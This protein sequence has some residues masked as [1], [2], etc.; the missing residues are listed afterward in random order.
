MRDHAEPQRYYDWMVWKMRQEDEKEM[1]DSE[2]G[3]LL[4][5]DRGGYLCKKYPDLQR[6]ITEV[7]VAEKLM[8]ERVPQLLGKG[9]YF[10]RDFDDELPF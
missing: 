2:Y 6:I 4:K 9:L 5:L 3:W 1:L 10:E 7:L 8:N